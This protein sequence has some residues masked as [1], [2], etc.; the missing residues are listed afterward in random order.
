MKK[1]ISILLVS[2]G[3][4]NHV[5]A[6]NYVAPS[7]SDFDNAKVTT[8]VE[9]DL[10]KFM[11]IPSTL[12]CLLQN[13]GVGSAGFANRTWK[14]IIPESKCFNPNWDGNITVIFQ[15]QRVSNS[16]P[17][18]VIG[19]MELESNDI[20]K[21]IFSAAISATAADAP[22]YGTFDLRFYAPYDAANNFTFTG[23]SI[24]QNPFD[25]AIA[26][27]SES[28]DSTRLE[29]TSSRNRTPPALNQQQVKM[30]LKNSGEDI[31]VVA[32]QK[33]V[34][35]GNSI[36]INGVSAVSHD[37]KVLARLFDENG[38]PKLGPG[39]TPLATCKARDVVF[40]RPYKTK[41][42][43]YDDGTD[44]ALTNPAI[45]INIVDPNNNNTPVS[46]GRG[47]IEA[48]TYWFKNRSRGSLANTEI[49]VADAV[50]ND[51]LMTAVWA[52]GIISDVKQIPLPLNVG[53]EFQVNNKTVY[54]DGLGLRYKND[55]TS[56][57]SN[58]QIENT[59]YL[60]IPMVGQFVR[61]KDLINNEVHI[62]PKV[63]AG[64][65]SSWEINPTAK[66]QFLTPMSAANDMLSGT[67]VTRFVC[68]S[69]YICPH[70]LSGYDTPFGN[71]DMS[72][73]KKDAN[74]TPNASGKIE[75]P[76]SLKK[77]L[78]Y[79]KT[80]AG[81]AL[82][83]KPHNY[84][85]T[86]LN[87]SNLPSGTLPATLYYDAD[88]DGNLDP[89]DKPLFANIYHQE[90]E[91]NTT[92][93]V[94]KW[95]TATPNQNGSGYSVTEITQDV[96]DV[97][98]STDSSSGVGSKTVQ[99][100]L[101]TGLYMVKHEDFIAGCKGHD[102]N[103]HN[104][105]FNTCASRFHFKSGARRWE[106]RFFLK[107][108]EGFI[109]QDPG[110]PV[111]YRIDKAQDLNNGFNAAV[112]A[113]GG[114][115]VTT[116]YPEGDWNDMESAKCVPASGSSVCEVDLG[117]EALDGNIFAFTHAG[118]E[119][120]PQP[121]GYVKFGALDQDTSWM[122]ALAPKTGTIVTHVMDNTARYVV[123][124]IEVGQRLANLGL[125]SCTNDADV[126]FSSL[127]DPIMAGFTYSDLPTLSIRSDLTGMPVWNDIPL[128]DATATGCYFQ[129]GE[130]IGT[131]N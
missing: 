80:A 100:N 111:K 98:I 69:D 113:Q 79:P 108:A 16:S 66:V 44:V 33:Q 62:S 129:N 41:L 36:Q 40:N 86:P 6:Q 25:M 89:G 67:S 78:W 45:E 124:N 114:Y 77:V 8:Y 60:N 91:L 37:G 59:Y 42:Y 53:D 74:G 95:Y 68:V 11:D 87:V 73:F 9:D 54:F 20:G 123:K 106:Q 10:N 55:D 50:N 128:A 110:I 102:G 122:P 4:A 65:V 81:T 13:G 103:S 43:N 29:L 83:F 49:P 46:N 52:P 1:F 101:Y 88:G 57:L 71:S 14:A 116:E 24:P 17:Q 82:D 117:P 126:N 28:S 127:S 34:T 63:N 109:E 64:V 130:K 121:G 18:E 118:T 90:R 112:S 105:S 104:T 3:L 92:G 58:G 70:T 131:C 115:T 26:T 27:L 120:Y 56:G 38:S 5:N 32:L 75:L 61:S 39:N 35:Q 12:A 96:K 97:K 30:E 51:A 84:L 94:D 125:A 47:R 48:N 93:K 72:I 2:T 85:L 76:W 15:T 19:W 23:G 21:Y 31:K 22:P 99:D 119:F 7:G 107:N